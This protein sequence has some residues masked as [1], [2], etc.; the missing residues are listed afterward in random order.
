MNKETCEAEDKLIWWMSDSVWWYVIVA[1]TDAAH[2][3]TV[4]CKK[5]LQ[6]N[7]SYESCSSFSESW[8]KRHRLNQNINLLQFDCFFDAQL[9]QY[10]DTLQSNNWVLSTAR[11]MIN[12]LEEMKHSHRDAEH[13][14][15]Q[16]YED[17]FSRSSQWKNVTAL[18][19][20]ASSH[21][22]SELEIYSSEMKS[23][24]FTDQTFF[25]TEIEVQE[26]MNLNIS[27]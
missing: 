9:L 8:R 4:W 1:D 13:F 18:M 19:L 23:N 25:T 20:L 22:Q 15:T 5:L 11:N 3:S 7:K 17:V 21:Q 24:S 27:K 26:L 14:R 10:Q 16:T 6:I 2:F 12:D